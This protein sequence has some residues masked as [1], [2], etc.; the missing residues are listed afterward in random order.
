MNATRAA[1]P[2]QA[3]A[4]HRF[5]VTVA[6]TAA[7]IKT[8]GMNEHGVPPQPRHLRIYPSSPRMRQTP[9]QS[10]P[11]TSAPPPGSASRSQAPTSH[12]QAPARPQRLHLRRRQL[13]RT[14]PEHG[15]YPPHH[16]SPFRAVFEGWCQCNLYGSKLA[17][18]QSTLARDGSRRGTSKSY[19]QDQRRQRQGLASRQ[20]AAPTK[21]WHQAIDRS[22]R[23]VKTADTSKSMTTTMDLNHRWTLV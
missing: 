9:S 22:K 3:P 2:E 17:S 21:S 20:A 18:T 14:S 4:S 19:H 7:G 23:R 8:A 16:I 15:R 11:S 10:A 6:S 13:R 1:D 12:H 5:S